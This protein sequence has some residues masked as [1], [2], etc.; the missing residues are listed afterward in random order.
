MLGNTFKMEILEE[1]YLSNKN[2][3]Y[4]GCNVVGGKPDAGDECGPPPSYLVTM[5][6]I[7]VAM[8]MVMMMMLMMMMSMKSY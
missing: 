3:L 1:K 6:V 7:M 2:G 5:M 4:D 8:M